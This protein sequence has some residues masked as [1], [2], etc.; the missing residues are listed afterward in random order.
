MFVWHCGPRATPAQH[1]ALQYN[2]IQVDNPLH[3]ALKR[4]N[5]IWHDQRHT[6]QYL[7]L[8]TALNILPISASSP[9]S[10]SC[11]GFRGSSP[12]NNPRPK[13]ITS[14]C[15]VTSPRHIISTSTQGDLCS[16][17]VDCDLVPAVDSPPPVVFA[18]AASHALILFVET[19]FSASAFVSSLI[20]LIQLLCSQYYHTLFLATEP[21]DETVFVHIS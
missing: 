19:R 2:T 4:K 8:E 21:R 3:Y 20:S 5:M 12:S 17:Y 11:S 10:P 9:S 18:L 1:N 6:V 7:R 14:H 15:H 13:H 16:C